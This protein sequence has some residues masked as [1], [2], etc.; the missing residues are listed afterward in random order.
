[1]N[2]LP[3]W[4]SP[5]LGGLASDELDLVTGLERHDSL[6]VVGADAGAALTAFLVLAAISLR[7]HATDGDLESLFDCLGNLVLVGVAKDFKGVLPEFG[8]ELVRLLSQA[9]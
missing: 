2:G 3:C 4:I 5:G 1:M 9:D 6:L 7:V 8:R